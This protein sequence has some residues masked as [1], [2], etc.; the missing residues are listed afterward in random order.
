MIPYGKQNLD[1]EDIQSVVDV[2]RSPLITQ[3][4]VVPAFERSISERVGSKYSVAFNSATSAL[5]SACLSL[6]L[7]KG[8]IGWTVPNSFVA[9][10]NCILLTGAKV[11][12]VDID[13]RSNNIS[14][15]K[16]SEKLKTAKKRNKLP[17]VLVPVH[18]SGQ[19]T[20][21]EEIKKLSREYGFK[22]LEDASHSIG[23]SRNNEMVGSCKW[24]DITVFSF[25][26]VKIITTGEGGMV[27]CNSKAT[28][29]KLNLLRSHGVTRDFDKKAY[30]DWFYKQVELGFNYRMT[31]IAAALGLSQLKK[32]E[33][34]IDSRKKIALE[35]DSL[36][37]GV[38]LSLPYSPKGNKSSW[39]LYVVNFDDP[40][41]DLKDIR[42][43]IYKDLV[44]N[45]YGVNVHYIPIHFHPFYRK[46]GFNIGDFPNSER[47]YK[48]ALSLP[49]F[50]NFKE[51]DQKNV[52][53]IIKSNLL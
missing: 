49:I 25:H 42:N 39:H 8:D 14:L 2:L 1:E 12:F 41:K 46:L 7:S 50:P 51:K 9:S 17:K 27:T 5:H 53:K 33:S 45:G 13:E 30:G 34:F 37:E 24:S 21:Q 22:I 15:E 48:T 23:A 4:K 38:P 52:V 44:K 3:G 11:D 29:N 47:Y 28:Y 10:A 19:P 18:F 32:L 26:P 36:L 31:D 40:S 6:G 16:L 20:I 43:I 35:Y